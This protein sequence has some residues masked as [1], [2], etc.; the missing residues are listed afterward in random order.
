MR[1]MSARSSGRCPMPF[2]LA[3]LRMHVHV[4]ARH[5]E[6]AEQ[7]ER[8][9]RGLESRGVGVERFEEAHLAR[10]V[11]AAVRHV[12]RCDGR[13]RQP[14]GDDAVL[15]VEL[16]MVERGRSGYVALRTCRPTPE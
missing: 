10:E 2:R 15:E 4:R 13:F 1:S 12:D 8:L 16:G 7:D 3:F 5:V 6:V 14:R 9:A 11:L